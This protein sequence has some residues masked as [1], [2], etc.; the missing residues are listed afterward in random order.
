MRSLPS[1]K[2]DVGIAA[3]KR[4]LRVRYGV[5]RLR[6]LRS[7]RTHVSRSVTA[8]LAVVLVSGG[9][10]AVACVSPPRPAAATTASRSATLPAAGTPTPIPVVNATVIGSTTP[11]AITAIAASGD[12]FW[13]AVDDVILETTDDGGHWSQGSSIAGGVASLSFTSPGDGWAGTSTGLL[14]TTDA[15]VT[16]VRVPSAGDNITRVRF[17]DSTHG[18]VGGKNGFKRTTDGGA[19]WMSISSACGPPHS[20]GG[21]FTFESPL[22]GWLM[23]DGEGASG[24]VAK[25]LYST[26]DGGETWQHFSYWHWG[27]DPTPSPYQPPAGG[28]TNDIFF[29]DAQHGWVS[30]YRAGI[31][32]TDDG[33]RTWHSTAFSPAD[34]EATSAIFT[35]PS[36]GVALNYNGV[37]ETSDGGKTWHVIYALPQIAPPAPSGLL[38][39]SFK[40]NGRSLSWAA[41]LPHYDVWAVA[42]GGADIWAVAAPCSEERLP[43][44]KGDPRQRTFHKCGPL[45]LLR[46]RDAG[47]SWTHY[48]LSDFA[49]QDVSRA[50]DGTLRVDDGHGTVLGASDDGRTW[51]RV[52]PPLLPSA[53]PPTAAPGR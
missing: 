9:L 32:E 17:V 40:I 45:A 8:I 38:P 29:F 10:A 39:P 34:P 11:D 46:S 51:T 30:E 6:M 22:A 36:R 43:P 15:G 31:V 28:G 48:V 21:I 19:T 53:A 12:S 33:A 24:E 14:H 47:R 23:C 50:A 1:R 20:G 2:S 42:L 5:Y 35:S 26:A 7:M 16:W 49:V 25:D 13:V 3:A 27:G 41:V 4:R 18:W 44:G 37:S 52:P